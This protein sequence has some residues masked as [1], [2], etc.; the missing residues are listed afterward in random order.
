METVKKNSS[1]VKTGSEKKKLAIVTCCIDD[2]GGSE[3][4]WFKAAIYLKE[5]GFEIMVLKCTINLYHPKFTEL[6]QRGFLLKELD[7]FS[8]K[9]ISERLLIRVWNKLKNND[10]NYLKNNFENHLRQFQPHHVLISQGINFD[11]L[12]FA[13]TC[14]AL[15]LPFSIVSQKAVEF[16]WPPPHER[17]AMKEVFQKAVKCFFVSRHN[18]QLT[19]EQFG[20]RFKNAKVVWNPVK[21][22]KQIIPYPSIENGFRL[23]CIGRLFIIDKGQDI[24]L[25]IASQQKWK[26]RPITISLFG[27]G[28]DEKGLKEMATL[29]GVTNVKFKGHVETIEEIWKEHHA[30]LL[31]SRSEGLPLVILETMA[32]G[33]MS[34]VSNAGGNSEIIKDGETGF[35]GEATVSSFDSLLEKAW[36]HRN[37]WNKMGKNAYEYALQTVP[38]FP[39]IDFA[40]QITELI[41]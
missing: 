32:A 12:L 25:R 15:N 6:A 4:L 10:E 13:N 36:V 20:F 26:K 11:G 38:S 39:E 37:D 34:I 33:R 40:K 3:D 5:E 28:V 21:V 8:K 23:A 14:M 29:L 1:Q 17:T 24:V 31:P 30:L 18:Q 9:S 27:T 16:Y 22:K 41:L 35:I 19:E 2:W 7:T